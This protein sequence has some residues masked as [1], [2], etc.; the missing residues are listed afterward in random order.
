[1]TRLTYPA[2][3]Q[4]TNLVGG[5]KRGREATAACREQLRLA[6]IVDQLAYPCAAF[7]IRGVPS[8]GLPNCGII[9][10]HIAV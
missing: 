10:E 5:V 3:Q 7:R 9:V 6:S 2:I 1:M 8:T 4:P